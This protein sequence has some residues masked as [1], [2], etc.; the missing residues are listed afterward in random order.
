MVFF[1][2]VVQV[3]TRIFRVMNASCDFVFE[4]LL[5]FNKVDHFFFDFFTELE[6]FLDPMPCLSYFFDCCALSKIT[7][8]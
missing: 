6:D 1:R 4:C 8:R 7:D 5:P 3:T 2:S